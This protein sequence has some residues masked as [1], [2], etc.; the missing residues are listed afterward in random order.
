MAATSAGGHMNQGT[1]IAAKRSSRRSRREGWAGVSQIERGGRSVSAGCARSLSLLLAIAFLGAAGCGGGSSSGTSPQPPAPPV[2]QTGSAFIPVM[3]PLSPNDVWNS[4]VAATNASVNAAASRR[5]AAAAATPQ[6]IN[7]DHWFFLLNGNLSNNNPLP[8]GLGAPAPASTP[9]VMTV[10]GTGNG[11]PAP[12]G[13]LGVTNLQLNPNT[14][15]Q[16]LWKAVAAPNGNFYLRSAES[17]KVNTQSTRSGNPPS[18]LV[19]FGGNGVQD[20]FTSGTPAVPL[21]LGY[22]TAAGGISGQNPNGIAIYMNQEYQPNVGFSGTTDGSQ[23]QQ[24][25]YNTANAQLTN[26]NGGQI[27]AING[28]STYSV[29]SSSSAPGNQWYAY[30]NYYLENVVNEPNSSPPFPVASTS[31]S[32]GTDQ[33]GEQGA[34]SYI[35]NQL[36]GSVAANQICSYEGTNYNGIRCQYLNLTATATLTTCES[37]VPA[38]TNPGTYSG[39]AISA[40]DWQ[41]VQTQITAECRYAADV[42]TT[43]N[44]YNTFLTQL[45]TQDSAAIAGI[46]SDVGIPNTQQ[47]SPIPIEIIEG[48]VYTV[49]SA[50][51]GP[52][53]GVVAN[54]ISTATT[55]A[56][57]ASSQ[58]QQ[59]L[60]H[61]LA[62][63]VAN[64][65]TSLGTTFQSITTG[66]NS[67][68]TSILE[69]W[70]RLQ[71]IGPATEF[72]G[73][74]GLGL[75]RTDLTD[76]ENEALKGYK[77]TVMQALLGAGVSDFVQGFPTSTSNYSTA[78]NVY[79]YPTNGPNNSANTGMYFY[80]VPGGTLGGKDSLA[81]TSSA[82]LND[83]FSNG[84]NQ[85]EV[86]N[87]INGWTELPLYAF[88]SYPT[89]TAVNGNEVISQGFPA[90]C[91]FTFGTVFNYTPTNLSVTF[92]TSA[93]LNYAQIGGPNGE[94]V[95][96]YSAELPA[97]GYAPV[98][99]LIGIDDSETFNV[100]VYDFNVST[101]NPVA[102]FPFKASPCSTVDVP[103]AAWNSGYNWAQSNFNA[104]SVVNANGNAPAPGGV[105]GT[106][107]NPNLQ[108]CGVNCP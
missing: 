49:L 68:E 105:W 58:N 26:G 81:A 11:F 42:Q 61:P 6:P 87:G 33:A 86:F 84:G 27:Y 32:A 102:S 94:S 18:M 106:L 9:Y 3:P 100:D 40:A 16:Q 24:W 19:G 14:T 93:S 85:F 4:A 88:Q 38:Y 41:A 30:P 104:Q 29:G 20:A 53:G 17:F 66:L 99:T 43:F 36:L 25:S 2:V 83:I 59:T 47:V 91:Q 107:I 78:S 74:N 101:S 72:D 82:V 23:F 80:Q 7:L 76:A 65:Y 44:Q 67:A 52:V 39:A 1:E 12:N 57:S 75:T 95:S 63:T 54:L 5:L 64:V 71:Q 22:D 103:S 56:L 37:V 48:L 31:P 73:Y 89:T 79:N 90:S 51:G 69:D 15:G 10:T 70:G 34:Y 55:V 108:A 13:S 28:Q 98:Y 46:V 62:T 77:I 35:S 45:F 96:S 60:T 50:V 97:Y 21:D 92:S 8:T